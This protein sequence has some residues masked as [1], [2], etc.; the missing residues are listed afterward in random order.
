LSHRLRNSAAVLILL[1]GI[2]WT[3]PI[4]PDRTDTDPQSATDSAAGPAEL[5][6]TA[7]RGALVIAGHTRSKHHEQRIIEAVSELFPAH[8]RKLEFR[9]LGVAPAW[10]DAATV[11][12]LAALAVMESPSAKLTE[13]GLRVRALVFDK[14]GAEHRL[15]ALRQSMP[16]TA[17]IDVQL[18]TIDTDATA[19]SFCER[20]FSAF[21]AGQ[22]AFEESG[23]EMRAS[24]YPV[25]D[26]VVALADACR[27][28]T[29][30]ITG[31]TDSTGNESLNRQLSRARA[32]AVAAYLDSRGIAKERLVVVGAGSS[33][34]VAD[35]ATRYGRSINRRIEIQFTATSD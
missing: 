26:G 8:S 2:A 1:A 25:L 21:R 24:A 3:V 32:A 16:P 22:V 5:Q 6:V 31:H 33:L 9:P 13:D 7:Y 20:Q 14:P 4:G 17:D 18:T 29:V 12:L 15:Q 34:P 10:W 11:E 27:A 30:T 28:A 23:T 19:A 35:N